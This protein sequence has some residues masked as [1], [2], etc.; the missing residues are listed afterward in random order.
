MS[1]FKNN[2]DTSGFRLPNGSPKMH[3][4]RTICKGILNEK[5]TDFT[6]AMRVSNGLFGGS[7]G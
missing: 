3:N 2:D 6:T 4:T 5:D 1:E 7:C